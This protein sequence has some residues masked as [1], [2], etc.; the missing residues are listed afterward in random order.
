MVFIQ[1]F[2]CARFCF[3]LNN[4][5][6][7]HIKV[8]WGLRRQAGRMKSLQASLGSWSTWA[9]TCSSEQ[10][11]ELVH[12]WRERG[13]AWRGVH[14]FLGLW[15]YQDRGREDGYHSPGCVHKGVTCGETPWDMM[16][17]SGT[18][19]FQ[20][21]TSLVWVISAFHR[22]KLQGQRL[23]SSSKFLYLKAL[24]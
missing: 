5:H 10:R 13:V 19:D 15:I 12:R 22:A 21:W 1:M 16:E 4:A 11:S 23:S 8:H 24:P 6:G 3:V 7:I 17:G 14:L 9:V 2:M 18:Q 20:C